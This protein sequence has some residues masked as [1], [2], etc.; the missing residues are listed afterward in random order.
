MSKQMLQTGE[1]QFMFVVVNYRNVEEKRSVHANS[2]EEAYGRLAFQSGLSHFRLWQVKKCLEMDV[3]GNPKEVPLPAHLR[4][5]EAIDWERLVLVASNENWDDIGNEAPLFETKKISVGRNI[6]VGENNI[7]PTSEV[8]PNKPLYKL[9]LPSVPPQSQIKLSVAEAT[10]YFVK[11]IVTDKDKLKYIVRTM[12]D[13]N[14]NMVY[15][16][17]KG[18][19][20]LVATSEPTAY[21]FDTPDEAYN[22][23][24]ALCK[25]EAK[26][27]GKK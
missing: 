7:G 18:F 15:F 26:K 13:L 14:P 27:G 16:K 21:Q 2:V 24:I 11:T 23:I 5:E 12:K 4:S 17:G 22:A 10:R 8:T 1:K 3:F 19:R 20:E 25:A 6:S 9:A